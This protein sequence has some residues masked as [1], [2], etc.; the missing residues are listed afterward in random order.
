MTR[1]ASRSMIGAEA[2]RAEAF[3]EFAPA[4]DAVTAL[5]R[6][7][8]VTP[9]LGRHRTGRQATWHQATMPPDPARVLVRP[10]TLLVPRCI[11]IIEGEPRGHAVVSPVPG[12]AG[13]SS[14]YV[15]ALEDCRQNQS[16]LAA[17]SWA[18]GP[19][20]LLVSPHARIDAQ[21]LRCLGS[22]VPRTLSHAP[23]H[24]SFTPRRSTVHPESCGAPAE[25]RTQYLPR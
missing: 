20:R 7:D 1:A 15:R 16:R 10:A 24:A 21:S 17:W 6:D 8:E 5:C 4:D 22:V 19:C 25:S 12:E 18:A 14:V 3:V 11:R 9:E 2:G 23:S 13:E